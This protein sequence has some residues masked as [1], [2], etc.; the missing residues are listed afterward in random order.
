MNYQKSFLIADR[1]MEYLS[2][3]VI[4]PIDP[5]IDNIRRLQTKLNKEE[6]IGRS[7]YEYYGIWDDPK[8]RDYLYVHSID[9]GDINKYY[10]MLGYLDKDVERTFDIEYVIDKD[11]NK[12]ENDVWQIR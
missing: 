3:Q 5:V 6:D 11:G 4:T 2:N 1:L 8:I 7:W 9:N 10:D 12:E